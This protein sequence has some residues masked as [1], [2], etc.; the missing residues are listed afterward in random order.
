MKFKSTFLNNRKA[1]LN[2]GAIDSSADN[3]SKRAAN[4]NVVIVGG[5]FAGL[6][7]G[8]HLIGSE[9]VNVCQ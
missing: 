7:V 6:A 4:Q 8:R 3:S 9:N 1:E 2:G 5:S